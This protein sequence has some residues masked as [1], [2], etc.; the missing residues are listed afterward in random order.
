M[1]LF[2]RKK[3]DIK[4]VEPV[5]EPVAEPVPEPVEK[6]EKEMEIYVAA[7]AYYPENNKDMELWRKYPVTLQGDSKNSAVP[8]EIVYDGKPV[9]RV[10]RDEDK[11]TVMPILSDITEAKLQIR[12]L[13][14]K[15][16]AGWG[17]VFIKYMG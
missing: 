14:P 2:K 7:F 8:I 1:R 16:S 10:R 17:Y 11:K 12:K 3:K 15:D 13:D 9:C 4:P 6:I 5:P